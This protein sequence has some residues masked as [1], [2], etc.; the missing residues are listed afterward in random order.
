[1]NRLA[2][3]LLALVVAAP[4]AAA[5]VLVAKKG[6]RYLFIGLKSEYDDTKVDISNWQIFADQSTGI[7]EREGYDGIW[8]KKSAKAKPVKYPMSE[9]VDYQFTTEPEALLD[10]YDSMST[11]AW[12]QA[13]RAFRS[14]ASDAGARPVY[15][16]Q[17]KFAIGD[18]Y[19]RAG[20]TKQAEKHFGAWDL[21]N[22][23]YTPEVY[24]VMGKIKI[25][26]KKY[27]EAR[28]WFEKIAALENIPKSWK[29][30]SRLGGVQV[31]IAE[32]KYTDAENNAKSIASEAVGKES[33]ND[34]QG[35]AYALQADAILKS[36]AEPRIKE[37]EAVARR[38]TDLKKL[39]SGTAAKVWSV[40]GDA[41][42]LQ[43][44]PDE[45]R[46]AYMR[47]V[48]LF[49]D[50][51]DFVAEALNNAGSCFLDL[52]GAAG[53]ANDQAKADDL[54]IKGIKLL[55]EC[56][57]RYRGRAA[58]AQA[59]ATYRKH[60]ADYEAALARVEKQQ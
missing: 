32:Q 43:K 28:Q 24:Q 4:V 25:L 52:A 9:V 30:R 51:P 35:M 49:T 23:R 57:G 46:Y 60:K 15:Q 8:I 26:R 17:A 5:D 45:A 7:I 53:K 42:Y 59:S 19:L 16:G 34:A 55:R 37:A 22:S 56:A 41:I 29:L 2:L 31:D 27:G 39:T 20:S 40:L 12:A 1:M 18:C 47:V 36:G 44:N 54:L 21:T 11:G 13:I 10:G 48:T 14:V 50:Q 3:V 6:N 58:A 38:G 33:L